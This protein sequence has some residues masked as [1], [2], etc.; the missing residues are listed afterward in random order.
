MTPSFLVEVMA[1][2]LVKEPFGRYQDEV[3]WFLAS[4]AEG[5]GSQ[6]A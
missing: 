2:G 5:V 4:A 6:L 3:R 1:L